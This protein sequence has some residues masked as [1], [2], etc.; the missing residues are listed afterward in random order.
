MIGACSKKEKKK[1]RQTQKTV[2]LGLRRKLTAKGKRQLIP[3]GE[4]PTVSRSPPSP[5]WEAG[6]SLGA[7]RVVP[8][9]RSTEDLTCVQRKCVCGGVRGWGGGE[10]LKRLQ[11]EAAAAAAKSLQSCPTLCDPIDGS[12]PGSPVPGYQELNTILFFHGMRASCLLV[13]LRQAF[14]TTYRVSNPTLI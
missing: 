2:L 5:G 4:V 10:L 9:D 1:K 12:P 8:L 3:K 13:S 7:V 11:E 14:I 6:G